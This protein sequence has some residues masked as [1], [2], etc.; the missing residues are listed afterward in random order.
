[1]KKIFV[2]LFLFISVFV[3]YFG[4]ATGF[5]FQS[6]WYLDYFNPLGQSIRQ[7][8]LDIVN[9]A[10][11][12]DLVQYGGKWYA[13]W[14]ILPALF[15][16]PVQMLKGRF[17]PPL[18]LTLFFASADVVI[19][20]FLLQRTKREFLLKLSEPFLWLVLILFAFGTTHLYVGTLGSVWHGDQMVSNFFGTL[21]IY[22]IFK[23]K[24]TLWS[25]FF[26]AL[27]FGT[28]LMG[29][30]T[31][32]LLVSIPVLLYSWDFLL[33]A[34]ISWSQRVRAIRNGIVIFGIPLGIFTGLFFLYNWLRFGNSLEYGYRYITEAPNLASLRE[35]YGIMSLSHVATN[36]RYMFFELPGFYWSNGLRLNFDL[37]G[38][39]IFFL[40]PP[41]LAI[42]FA[43][44]D[45][46]VLSLWIAAI[47]TM[48][49]SLLIYSTG[50]MQFGYRYSLDVT[51]VLVLLSLFGMKG[52]LNVLY[53][54][55][56]AF[57]VVVY[58]M[59][60]TALR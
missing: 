35:R 53:V 16:I 23:K 12:Y 57:S 30:A 39:S 24:R 51:A 47:I 5:S 46:Y 19:F 27:C 6:K 9:P 14:G 41:F 26:S 13:P 29:R 11:T 54:I 4:I 28:A 10:V 36:I 20:Y 50:W 56:V 60:I 8:R 34:T 43:K 33:P 55:G 18:Y 15:L 49:P 17:V 38:N 3:L 59:G 7:G 45:R 37:K 48:I 32:V 2:P 1:M 40:T 52:K 44:L 21:G 25:Y 58:Q 22:S 42:F 31:I